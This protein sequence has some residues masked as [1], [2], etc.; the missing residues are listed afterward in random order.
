MASR[1]PVSVEGRLSRI[2]E[3]L[4]N[5]K[6]DRHQARSDRNDLLAEMKELKA[7]VFQLT[8]SMQSTSAVVSQ[9]SLEN[10]GLRLNK[11][12]ERIDLLENRTQNLPLIETEVIFWR[13][14]LGGGFH[15]LWKILAVIVS[16]GAVGA[17]VDKYWLH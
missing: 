8:Q 10:Y 2:E 5:L 16:S 15:A 14:V 1:I 9:M 4:A 3:A 12:D 6:D 17:L 11:H 13:R 7:S